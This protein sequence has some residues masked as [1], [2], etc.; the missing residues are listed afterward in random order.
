M[1]WRLKFQYSL[2]RFWN[3]P[4]SGEVV[5]FGKRFKS[6]SRLGLL[7][8][9]GYLEEIKRISAG[10]E[11]LLQKEKCYVVDVGANVGQFAATLLNLAPNIFIES[12]EP[13]MF[14]FELLQENSRAYEGRWECSNI[15]IGDREKSESLYFV[16]SKSAQGSILEN[17][18][19]INLIS[20]RAKMER[21]SIKIAPFKKARSDESFSYS[22]RRIDLLKIDVEG[23]ERN[24][25]LGM[26]E[27]IFDYLWVEMHYDSELTEENILDATGYLRPEANIKLI[28]KKNEKE[29]GFNNNVLYEVF[30]D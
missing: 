4:L 5:W 23:Y 8:L 20:T 27:T 1:S 24:A 28:S 19:S 26:K 9:P 17:K 10:V 6:D 3:L 18:S 21:I 29:I 2:S 7:L 22:L 12:F 11:N 14:V 16:P 30:I 25:L 15:G 13:N